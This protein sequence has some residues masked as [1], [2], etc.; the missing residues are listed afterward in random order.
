MRAVA[1]FLS[2]AVLAAC[3]AGS[4][5]QDKPQGGES[6]SVPESAVTSEPSSMSTEVPCGANTGGS[7]PDAAD[8]TI[9]D[10]AVALPSTDNAALQAVEVAAFGGG[11]EGSDIVDE[12]WWWSKHGLLVKGTAHIEVEVPT[13]H[14]GDMRIGWGGGPATPVVSVTVDCDP[15]LDFWLAF[16]GGYWVREP[17]CYPVDVRVDGGPASQVYIGIGAPCPG[18]EP[19]PIGPEASG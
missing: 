1:A 8:W 3:S 9:L 10:E 6:S 18:Q 4:E 19:P 14:V 2:V 13:E 7:D 15:Q 16:P 17:G 11:S 12:S 5:A